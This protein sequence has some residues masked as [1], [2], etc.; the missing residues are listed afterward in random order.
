MKR[1]CVLAVCVWLVVMAIPSLLL[2]QGAA[3]AAEF[4]KGWTSYASFEGSSSTDGTVMDLTSSVGYNFTKMVG[5]DA[6]VPIYF[7][8]NSVNPQGFQTSNNGLGD[9]FADL[10]LKLDGHAV[11]YTSTVTGTVPTGDS[12]KGLSTGSATVDWSNRFEHRFDSLTPFAVAGLGNT[13]PDERFFHRPYMTLGFMSHFEGGATYDFAK[14]F[15]VGASGYYLL[16]GGTQKIY[17]RLFDQNT[18]GFGNGNHG[19]FWEVFP[20]V[21]GPAD[22]TRDNGLSTWL[23]INPN[24]LID[25]EVGYSR[26][27]HFDMNTFSFGIGFNV[28]QMFKHTRL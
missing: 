8:H 19:R 3:P 18:L 12:K 15:T 24:K 14:Y 28:G 2:A 7:V 5:L 4:E 1:H 27:T 23:D 22:L 26:S 20:F 21:S 6:G 16:P 17:S 25:L 10:R 11:N 13:T 9:I